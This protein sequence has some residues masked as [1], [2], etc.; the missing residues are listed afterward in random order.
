MWEISGG[1]LHFVGKVFR[2]ACNHCWVAPALTFSLPV[3]LSH[4]TSVI[5][6]CGLNMCTVFLISVSDIS[7]CDIHPLSLQLIPFT[8]LVPTYPWTS[9]GTKTHWSYFSWL[10]IPLMLS[11]PLQQIISYHCH[12]FLHTH[13]P[14]LTCHTPIWFHSPIS[15][16]SMLV[17]M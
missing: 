15:L 3:S 2:K 1:A 14:S 9:A 8:T 16:L 13:S 11:L 10:L 17:P 6:S 12:F 4:L 5:H 7:S